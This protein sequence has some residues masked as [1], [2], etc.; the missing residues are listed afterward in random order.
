MKDV[1]HYV[2]IDELRKHKDDYVDFESFLKILG[3][4]KR[5]FYN[6]RYRYDIVVKKVGNKVFISVSS[7]LSMFE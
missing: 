1:L 7:I 3:I 2:Q 5:T 6:Y 4:S